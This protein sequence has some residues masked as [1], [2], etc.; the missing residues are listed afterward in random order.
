MTEIVISS[1]DDLDER[2]ASEL[3]F[4]ERQF[5]AE[6]ASATNK[7]RTKKDVKKRRDEILD[8]QEAERSKLLFSEDDQITLEKLCLEDKEPAEEISQEK[9]AEPGYF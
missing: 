1:I 6:I 8:R 9:T 4:Y 2:H 5:Q 3:A 7:K